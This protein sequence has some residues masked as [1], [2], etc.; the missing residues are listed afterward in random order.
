M[1]RETIR[2]ALHSQ[3]AS[4]L[5]MLKEAIRACP[6]DLWLDTSS[7]NR[8][9]HVAYHTLF[10]TDLYLS[11]SEETFEPWP[12]IRENYQ[13]MGAVPWDPDVKPVV[14][15][16]YAR[17]ELDSYTDAILARLPKTLANFDLDGPSGF[18]WIPLTKFEHQLYNIRHIQ[19]HSGQLIDRL[20]GRGVHVSW[21]G[22]R[23]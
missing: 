20:R 21:I 11:E 17:A 10:Y 1:N 3:Y 18:E 2:A 8:F 5:Q 12:K 19:H 9:W 4:S 6:E 23:D 15:Q 22:K 13:Y 7:Q 14:D 16:P